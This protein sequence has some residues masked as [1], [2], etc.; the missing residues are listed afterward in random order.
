MNEIGNVSVWIAVGFGLAM[1]GIAY[2]AVIAWT[3][4]HGYDEGYT[5][6]EV[7][8]GVI[9]TLGFVA[10]VNWLAALIVLVGFTFSGTPMIIGSWWRHVQARR[11]AQEMLR[12]DAGSGVAERGG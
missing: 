6:F 11:R 12:N 4:A 2:N 3:Q 10:M 9:G 5:S 7:V 1:F 8:V